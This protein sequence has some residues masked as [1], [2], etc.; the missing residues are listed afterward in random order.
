MDVISWIL[1]AILSEQLED[2]PEAGPH[3]VPIG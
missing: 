1:A 2:E 3:V